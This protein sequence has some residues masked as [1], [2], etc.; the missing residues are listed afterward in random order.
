[1]STGETYYYEPAMGHG[2]AHDPLNAIV[3]PRPIGWISTHSGDG[4]L[5]LA[6][7][8]FFNLFCY[9]PP[10]IGFASTGRKDGLQNAEATGEFAWSLVTRALADQMNATSAAVAPEVEEFTLAGLTP[11]SSRRIGVPRAAASPVSL[12]CRCT[13]ILRLQGA[14]GREADSW[15]VLGEIVGV[16]IDHSLVADGHYDTVAA[17]PVVRG[18]GPADY[19][20]IDADARFRMTRPR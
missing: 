14:D 7:Y 8:G 3:A 13:Q 16:H 1:V 2:L 15:L 18:G 5:N 6:P 9:R 4:H 19:F 11:A 10:I 12:E 20:A 17:R